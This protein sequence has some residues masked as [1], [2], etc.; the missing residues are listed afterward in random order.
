MLTVNMSQENLS[1]YCSDGRKRPP[2]WGDGPF[3]AKSLQKQ[4]KFSSPNMKSNYRST[5]L[6]SFHVEE[7]NFFKDLGFPVHLQS[8]RPFQVQ[9]VFNNI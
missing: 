8:R 1:L 5:D 3:E 6:L 4:R 7:Q 2:G 9:V